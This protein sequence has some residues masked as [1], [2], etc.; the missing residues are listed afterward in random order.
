MKKVLFIDRDGTLIA[1]PPDEQVDSLQKLSFLPG[2]FRALGDIAAAGEYELV[3]VSNQD[4]LGTASFP[5]ADF[6][7][8]HDAML[9]AFAGEGVVF[10]EVFIDRHVPADNAPT[11]KP[12][13]GMLAK[14]IGGGY[15]LAASFVVGDRR[16]DMELAQNL[17]AR[18]VWLADAPDTSGLE[19]IVAL[20]SRSWCDIARFLLFP[21]RTAVVR[22]T[23]QETDVRAEVHLDGAGKADIHTGLG[24]FDHMI[25]QFA[26]H[27]RIDVTVHTQADL[28]VDE[29]HCMEDTAL[30][31]GQAVRQALGRKMGIER[32]GFCL[33]MDDALAQVA[34]DFGGRPWLVWAADF[35]RE[36]IGD[37][38]TEMFMHV[39]K[40]F[41]DAALCTVHIT[42]KGSNEHHKI[43]AIFKAFGRA[44]RAA[45]QRDSRYSGVPSTKGVV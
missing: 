42:A 44:V 45:V 38:P 36:R 12:G 32:Y 20:A 11:R 8:A 35:R 3:V 30:A 7:P 24:F 43:E 4:G 9:R 22:R 6:W 23:T 39:F 28:H 15:D 14:Y 21:Q 10:S 33:P 5:E 13:T 40:S 27:S 1:E 29:H 2:V 37:V 16:T 19:H 17:G 34:V 18:G 25:E 31:L 41:C 26:F